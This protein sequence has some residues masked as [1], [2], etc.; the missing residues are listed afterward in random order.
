MASSAS[1]S[2][3]IQGINLGYGVDVTPSMQIGLTACST[4][5]WQSTS[6]VICKSSQGSGLARS[7]IAQIARS[8]GTAGSAFS[9]DAPVVSSQGTNSPS[10]AG[11]SITVTGLNFGSIDLSVT[12]AVGY[13]PCAT[14][15]WNS[16][17]S[18]GC[19]LDDGFGSAMPILATIDMLVG[20][21]FGVFSFDSPVVSFVRSEN[22]VSSGGTIITLSG[23]NFGFSNSS[24]TALLGASS[25][26]TSVWTS[27]TSVE[28][29]LTYGTGAKHRSV[30]TIDSVAGTMIS[31]FSYDSPVSSFANAYNG[32]STGGVMVT[33]S[34][35]NFAGGDVTPTIV[36]DSATICTSVSWTS[37]T[38]LGCTKP[39]G[40]GTT[41]I[42]TTVT[43]LAGTQSAV[44]TFDSPVITRVGEPNIAVSASGSITLTGYN[45]SPVDRTPVVYI[46]STVSETTVW[47]SDTS[48]TCYI[49]AKG[50]GKDH[51]IRII[52]ADTTS[53]AKAIFTYDAPVVTLTTYLTSPNVGGQSVTLNGQNFGQADE[54]ATA[55][56]GFTL[57]GTTSWTS[58][59]T[60]VCLSPEGA[61]QALSLVMTIASLV[62]TQ[63]QAY[64]YA[65]P[66]ITA[67][68]GVNGA[69]T[70]SAQVTIYGQNFGNADT[71][72]TTRL[73]STVCSTSQWRSATVIECVTA[74]GS[75][76][77]L[78]AA[79][80]V[81]TQVGTRLTA[82]S[83]DNPVV[84]SMKRMNGAVS[85][86]TSVT[87][88][89][90]NFG[91][92]DFSPSIMIGESMCATSVWTANTAVTC[93]L[94][95]GSGTGASASVTTTS[96]VGTLV[97]A[98]SY[99]APV[100]TV[101][102]QSNSPL[103]ASSLI[104]LT[105][106]NF[107]LVDLS[108]TA[109]IGLTYCS[110]TAYV[111]NTAMKCT[112][113]AG[114]GKNQPIRAEFGSVVAT[115]MAAF[116]YDAPALTY[117]PTFNMGQ[118]GLATMTI[119]GTNFGSTDTSPNIAVGV[120]SCVKSQWISA[121]ALACR[122][123]SG[124]GGGLAITSEIRTM[125]AT[126]SGVFS[127][128]A[129]VLTMLASRNG[130]ATAGSTVTLV[131]KNFGTYSGHNPAASI[132]GSACK[133]NT[134]ISYTSVLCAGSAVGTGVS[135]SVGLTVGGSGG[136]T[137][138]TFYH[139][140]TYDEPVALSLASPNS[141]VTGGSVLTIIGGNFGAVGPTPTIIIGSTQCGTSVWTSFSTLECVVA[142][143]S[144]KDS[145]RTTAII[146]SL[147]GTQ[148]STFS[149]DA[150]VLTYL[151]GNS[152]LSGAAEITVVGMNFGES[153]SS[154]VL[155]TNG[156]DC[157]T[158]MWVA[159][160]ALKCVVPTGSGLQLPIVSYMFGMYSTAMN[161]MTYDSPVVT[162]IASSA[163]NSPVTGGA[164]FTLQGFN[165]GVTATVNNA[166]P[167][168]TVADTTNGTIGIN[169]AY[170]PAAQTIARK[171]CNS[172]SWT[173][174]SE[175]VCSFSS[176]GGGA[177]QDVGV[178]ADGNSNVLERSWTFDAPVLQSILQPNG[179][180]SGGAALSILGRNFG[181]KY[182]DSQ[183]KLYK[184]SET[185]AAVVSTSSKDI[186]CETTTW[187]S[188][189]SVACITPSGVGEVR[190]VSVDTGCNYAPCAD[191]S[192][193][194]INAGTIQNAFTYD[195]PV[196]TYMDRNN[197]PTKGGAQV[198]FYGTN[199]GPI[200]AVLGARIGGT[201][202]AST[203][204]V[205]NT[206]VACA[207][208]EGKASGSAGQ[209]AVVTI[210]TAAGVGTLL[211]AF[212]YDSRV[213]SP[214]PIELP[215]GLIQESL[216]SAAGSSLSG[217]GG[218]V[219]DDAQIDYDDLF[220]LRRR[221]ASTL[222]SLP[223][224][225]KYY[226]QVGDLVNIT[227]SAYA[228]DEST[229]VLL[230]TW[231]GRSATAF[232]GYEAKMESKPSGRTATGIFTW[233][234]AS[235]GS[236]D[237]CAQLVDSKQV[238]QDY[239]CVRVIILSCQHVV[240]PGETLD[241]IASLYKISPRTIWWLN[242]DLSGRNALAVGQLVKIGRT[243]TIR[244][245]ESLTSLVRDLNSTWYWVNKHNPRMIFFPSTVSMGSMSYKTRQ[246][247]VG[248]EYCV[249]ADI[250]PTPKYV[251]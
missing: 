183:G 149:Y 156:V 31:V 13:T 151:Y 180:T 173:S 43:A 197:G 167:L 135:K 35:L 108:A 96:L 14:S 22:G 98:F 74:F 235:T 217:T 249:V 178:T 222:E 213:Y 53:T 76:A 234:P 224:I 221:K 192:R 186:K 101:S 230:A 128:D 245:G 233:S 155:Q 165:F 41:S 130:P 121:T 202:C 58:S 170:N 145:L 37:F 142:K 66:E 124:V 219:F 20:T 40:Y 57:C 51:S 184:S 166:N 91:M 225:T 52:D 87:I 247:F 203:K 38:S 107:G 237:L 103:T 119:Y 18:I 238:V 92:E 181:W 95:A 47:S 8:I 242:K 153:D 26:L 157:S 138:G 114:Y 251:A 78:A 179:P 1:L 70:G 196:V 162:Y 164:A 231:S 206:A 17:T 200:D 39:A 139:A 148:Q 82:F 60:I 24:P 187:I 175:I 99:D 229:N 29:A 193:V 2:L 89:G 133:D 9:Y 85:G 10:S 214:P 118:N 115:L 56:L 111:T 4:T 176:Q 240:Q 210:G 159:N 12:T 226:Y 28:C 131:G 27:D 15:T 236:Y 36:I 232:T 120:T 143:G 55:R 168:F 21:R 97:S 126:L 194:A 64:T 46:G 241:S 19:Y 228:E 71:T 117:S 73:G 144:G 125:T 171:W 110:A 112:T 188:D 140:F 48:V 100:I 93:Q 150:P 30:L 250:S 211:S 152:P 147:V 68:V 218:A 177:N 33:V 106:I 105:G 243:Y 191:V 113:A 198:T 239:L 49:G 129:P 201:S 174:D 42:A 248:R 5:S 45:F 88:L 137:V 109:R 50:L 163:S 146:D 23:K 84:T 169:S 16:A 86:G 59:S 215:T 123:L 160:S 220:G 65:A 223:G 83:Y 132:D 94:T 72:P 102:V 182:S 3:T 80:T 136:R 205:T 6:T 79:V 7:L 199:F 69:A 77:D 172:V 209:S 122:P 189:S 204:W 34:G 185:P 127:Y 116:T 75:G 44:F 25:C 212:Q 190:S 32:P 195:G 207:T 63:P 81:A 67:T 141:P 227:F 134:W 208:P 244:A 246:D 154:P 11:I 216:V 158:S 61:G 161:A 54:T 104:T 90:S 62:G